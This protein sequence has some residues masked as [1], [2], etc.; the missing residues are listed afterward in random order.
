[1]KKENQYAN[2]QKW[3]NKEQK[4]IGILKCKEQKEYDNRQD[5]D[6]EEKI[7]NSYLSANISKAI[8]TLHKIQGAVI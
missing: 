8:F 3:R 5:S 4:K 6:N 2:R 7:C 1:M